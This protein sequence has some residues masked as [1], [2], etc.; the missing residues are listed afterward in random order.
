MKFKIFIDSDIILDMLSKREPF[1][2]SA[3]ILF[4]LIERGTLKG[5]TSPVIFSNLHYILRK[6]ISKKETITSLKYLKS[7]IM[8]LPVDSRAIESA[9]DS[10]FDDFEDA[11]QY[12]CAEQN[13]INYFIT[14]NK[15][16]YSKAQIT[17]LSANEFLSM[18]HT[19]NIN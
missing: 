13:G 15:L 17:I 5:Y 10:G 6:R 11:I 2:G 18:L 7:L 14:R 1:Y 4:S 19:L 16:D 3:A 9:L 8:I 12:Y